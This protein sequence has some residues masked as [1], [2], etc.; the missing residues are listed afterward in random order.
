MVRH[1]DAALDGRLGG[2][3]KRADDGTG[4]TLQEGLITGFKPM[5]S[6]KICQ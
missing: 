1:L 4:A 6:A 5:I 3:Q 2:W